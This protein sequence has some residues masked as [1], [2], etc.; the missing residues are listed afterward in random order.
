MN[1]L[2]GA[3]KNGQMAQYTRPETYDGWSNRETW[4]TDQ[5]IKQDVAI[6]N[7][8]KDLIRKRMSVYKKARDL[9]EM[10]SELME[11]S[12]FRID[13]NLALLEAAIDRIKWVEII[14]NNL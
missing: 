11:I 1:I 5:W 8:F 2:R 13:L 7:Y 10:M 9:E 4:L 3:T 14:K 6:S 12:G